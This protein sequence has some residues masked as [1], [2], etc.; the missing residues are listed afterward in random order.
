MHGSTGGSGYKRPGT[1]DAAQQHA[2]Q[3]IRGAA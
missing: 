2:Y 1:L 3:S